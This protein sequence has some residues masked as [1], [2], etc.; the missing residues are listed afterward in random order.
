[1]WGSTGI[2][3]DGISIPDSA[4]DMQTTIAGLKPGNRMPDPT[5]P[6]IVL[7]NGKP[8]LASSCTG[9]AMHTTNFVQDNDREVILLLE[10]LS[11]TDP[12][13]ASQ[14]GNDPIRY[15]VREAAKKALQ[16]LIKKI[17]HPANL[18]YMNLTD[19]VGDRGDANLGQ[20]TQTVG[21]ATVVGTNGGPLRGARL[22]Q[23]FAFAV[24]EA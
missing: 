13:A 24:L 7:K 20:I 8:Y 23:L 22:I 17:G 5:N 16:S 19:L 3:V 18:Y 21:T 12:Y 14:S 10:L 4:I 6:L 2:F 15:P 1:L 11:Q 9:R